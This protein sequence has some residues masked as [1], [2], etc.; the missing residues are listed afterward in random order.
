MSNTKS[1]IFLLLLAIIFFTAAITVRW[2]S[3]PSRLGDATVKIRDTVIR[4]EIANTK[5]K[6]EKGLGGRSSLNEGEG[7]LFLFPKKDQYTFWMK[8]MQFPI[9]II[10]I[11]D[12]R[13]A[14]VTFDVPV[15]KNGDLPLYAPWVP[16]D[17]VLE[18]P[19]NFIGH[20]KMTI[21]DPVEIHIDK[22]LQI[23]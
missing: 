19:A 22:N 8:D 14:D 18:V 15:S 9:D 2:W 11:A 20:H 12:G 23:E 3:S 10:W 6:R 17:R 5:T 7:M 4:V 16:V 21:G 1:T 13:V